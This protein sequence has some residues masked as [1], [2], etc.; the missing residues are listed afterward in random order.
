TDFSLAQ[1]S[2]LKT[3]PANAGSVTSLEYSRRTFLEGSSNYFFAGTDKGLYVF[4]VAGNGFNVNT[5]S[6]L[7]QAPF[8]TGSWEAV[9]QI[10][11]SVVTITTS[12]KSLYVLTFEST[13]QAPLK[14]K[15][16][17]IPF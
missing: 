1:N 10:A 8:S 6:T 3:L 15:L 5:L 2:L 12:G 13:A 16:Y 14:N 11:G 4:S 17:C 7:D 9:T